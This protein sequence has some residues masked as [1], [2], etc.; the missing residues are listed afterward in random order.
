[1]TDCIII[2]A[3]A[4]LL[5][6]TMGDPVYRL[7]P[8]RL[9]GHQIAWIEGLLFRTGNTNFIGGG[10]LFA[11]TLLSVLGVVLGVTA[12]WHVFPIPGTAVFIFLVY[13]SVGFRDMFHHAYPIQAA[14]EEGD[15]AQSRTR[16]QRIVGRDAFLLDAGEITRAAVESVAENFVDG[17]LSVVF[18]FA[19]GALV[20][21]AAGFPP[22]PVAVGAAIVYRAVN[23]LDAMVGYRNARYRHFGTVSARADDILNFIPARLS[24]PVIA[25]AA[26]MCRMAP[27]R[28][29][30]TA[31]RDRLCH[32]SPNAG[33]AESCVAGALGIRLGGPVR[34]THK[35]AE[36]PWMGDPIRN[37]APFH[38]HETCRLVFCAGWM[39]ILPVIFIFARLA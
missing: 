23:T 18:W 34:Y 39:A 13:S 4:F 2:L 37:I 21:W 8:V 26:A 11:A 30:K 28:C 31:L 6:I 25:A 29:I 14:L 16:L 12:L 32:I 22:A 27:R 15:L 19:A 1:M 38:I 24:L 17:F 10:L 3:G 5:D 7:H 9:M 20:A 35:T 36:K 33:H